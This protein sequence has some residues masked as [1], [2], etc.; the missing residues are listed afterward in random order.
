M[1]LFTFGVSDYLMKLKIRGKLENSLMMSASN[2]LS[3]D[4]NNRIYLTN[5]GYR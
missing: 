4:D 5:T 2:S 3:W 1:F